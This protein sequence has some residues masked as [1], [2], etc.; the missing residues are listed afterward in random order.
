MLWPG[1]HV[2]GLL[3]LQRSYLLTGRRG[4][5]K[6]CVL[7]QIVLHA[8]WDALFLSCRFHYFCLKLACIFLFISAGTA[9]WSVLQMVTL[10]CT[11]GGR[12]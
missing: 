11:R 1:L 3:L 12:R 2:V 8:R 7:N 4:S 9:G 10:R 5:G 6:S